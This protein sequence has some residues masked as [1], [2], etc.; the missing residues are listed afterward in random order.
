M[1][2]LWL[3]YYILSFLSGYFK[4]ESVHS[5]TFRMV[6]LLGG[7]LMMSEKRKVNFF[8]LDNQEGGDTPSTLIFFETVG[9]EAVGSDEAWDLQ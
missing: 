6:V 9:E 7:C 4:L 8:G 2:W 1:L 3:V 5:S